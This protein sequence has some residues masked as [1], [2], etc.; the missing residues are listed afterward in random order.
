MGGW[1]NIN[2]ISPKKTELV[3]APKWDLSGSD[4]GVM[5]AWPILQRHAASNC[6]TGLG[7][8]DINVTSDRRN[9]K[10]P[11]RPSSTRSCQVGIRWDPKMPLRYLKMINICGAETIFVSQPIPTSSACVP[12]MG[13]T[14]RIS[15]VWRFPGQKITTAGPSHRRVPSIRALCARDYLCPCEKQTDAPKYMAY[16]RPAWKNL[17]GAGWGV[18][19]LPP[20]MH[21]FGKTW[22]IMNNL[23]NMLAYER[24]W[25]FEHIPLW[26]KLRSKI[27]TQPACLRVFLKQFVDV[28][29]SR[30]ENHNSWAIPPK[31]P[32]NSCP[33]RPGL[34]VSMRKTNRCPQIH[35]ILKACMKEPH[36]GRLRCL[37]AATK[38]AQF[39]QNMNNHEQSI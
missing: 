23:Y 27:T 18:F 14:G 28:D 39:W 31:S 24:T 4:H 10:R 21:S 1:A 7:Y 25:S 6:P 35:G 17:T 26:V 5:R 12:K 8:I 29:C 22:T 9:S 2:G 36:R 16:W 19:M 38:D 33:L 32:V 13:I 37:H 20:R 34:L 15:T 30:P 11:S 3:P